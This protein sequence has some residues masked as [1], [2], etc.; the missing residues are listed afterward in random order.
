MGDRND[1][2]ICSFCKRGVLSGA[3]CVDCGVFVHRSCA[4]LA[5]SVSDGLLV[6]AKCVCHI[7]HGIPRSNAVLPA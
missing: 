7:H 5:N 3:S 1:K 2:K 4:E 6:S